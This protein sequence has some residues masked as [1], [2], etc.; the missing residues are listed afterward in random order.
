[1]FGGLA[2]CNPPP[3]LPPPLLTVGSIRGGGQS[4]RFFLPSTRIQRT[5]Q[6]P[7][8]TANLLLIGS[9]VCVRACAQLDRQE[10]Q[11]ALLLY[12]KSLAKTIPTVVAHQFKGMGKLVDSDQVKEEIIAVVD[13]V[14]K[15]DSTTPPQNL[16]INLEKSITTTTR[17]NEQ[18]V[19]KKTTTV[20][21]FS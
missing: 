3:P 9:H 13:E 6:Q 12:M 5:N 11:A 10:L 17:K 1:M 21:L 2:C 4:V 18:K 8:T 19:G 16:K 7:V 15:K 20:F 14:K